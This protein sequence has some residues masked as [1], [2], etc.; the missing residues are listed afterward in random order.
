M[1]GVKRGVK[2]TGSIPMKVQLG[3]SC[4]VLLA[5]SVAFTELV[6][7]LRRWGKC[8]EVGGK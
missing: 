1:V 2:S 5:F 6:A 8:D 3:F 4:R 7:A